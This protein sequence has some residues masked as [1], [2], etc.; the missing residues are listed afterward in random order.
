MRRLLFLLPFLI[1]S[2]CTKDKVPAVIIDP[3]C[4]DSILFSNE[5]LPLIE[6]HC[7]GCHGIGNSTGFTFTNHTN[8][9]S[10]ASAIIGSMRGSGFQLMPQGGPALQDSIIQRFQCWVNQGKINN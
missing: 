7:T 2:S 6:E 3:N 9:S 5:I 10:N 1:I 4:T 8:I